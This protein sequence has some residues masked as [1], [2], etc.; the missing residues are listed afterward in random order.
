MANA[1]GPAKELKRLF[2]GKSWRWEIET[3]AWATNL[4]Q[5]NDDARCG[6]TLFLAAIFASFFGFSATIWTSSGICALAARP[7][8]NPT[9]CSLLMLMPPS[10]ISSRRFFRKTSTSLFTFG[11]A[12]ENYDDDVDEDATIISHPRSV[13]TQWFYTMGADFFVWKMLEE[14]RRLS[15][16][17]SVQKS[18]SRSVI[19]SSEKVC[20]SPA[21]SG[22]VPQGS[23]MQ[24]LCFSSKL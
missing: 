8:L 23:L 19:V 10:Y 5:I 13:S 3:N 12:F 2:V 4:R 9:H 22:G 17:L 7:T 24:M 15:E 14:R 21:G 1:C 18:E 11:A 6:E 20:Q 16:I